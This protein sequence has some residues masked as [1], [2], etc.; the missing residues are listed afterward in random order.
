MFAGIHDIGI[1]KDAHVF[2]FRLVHENAE[3]LLLAATREGDDAEV[4]H[5]A[6]SIC[7]MIVDR[8]AEFSERHRFDVVKIRLKGVMA[9]DIPLRIDVW[10]EQEHVSLLLVELLWRGLV[11]IP[12]GLRVQLDEHIV[13]SLAYATFSEREWA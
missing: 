4:L 13:L 6:F 2:L 9:H 1:H 10:H 3:A 7:P 5:K 12:D 8:I 11:Q